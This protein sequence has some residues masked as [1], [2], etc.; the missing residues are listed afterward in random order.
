MPKEE[1]KPKLKKIYDLSSGL[2]RNNKSCPK[3]GAGFFMA[4]HRNR[5]ACGNCHYTE[6]VKENK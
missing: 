2:K 3:C 6:F 4:K 1:K 5:W